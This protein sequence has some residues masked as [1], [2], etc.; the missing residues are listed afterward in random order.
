MDGA[1]SVTD[2]SGT[3]LFRKYG[4][5]ASCEGGSR[6]VRSCGPRRNENPGTS[7][8]IDGWKSHPPNGPGFLSNVCQVRVSRS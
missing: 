7:N 3:F 6:A 8:S 5:G 4:S 2:T 1:K